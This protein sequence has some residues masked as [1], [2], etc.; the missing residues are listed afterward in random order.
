MVGTSRRLCISGIHPCVTTA[1]LKARFQ[2]FG[3]VI[4]GPDIIIRDRFD[5]AVIGSKNYAFAF[6]SMLLTDTQFLKFQTTFSNAKW[7]GMVLQIADASE[8]YTERLKREKMIYLERC[9]AVNAEHKLQNHGATQTLESLRRSNQQL[10]RCRISTISAEDKMVSKTC[11]SW[12]EG[13]GGLPLAVVRVRDP[14]THMVVKTQPVQ[15]LKRHIK[16]KSDCSNTKSDELT[17]SIQEMPY[18]GMIRYQTHQP[19]QDRLT[20]AIV[21]EPAVLSEAPEHDNSLF[22]ELKSNIKSNEEEIERVPDNLFESDDE[23]LIG[24]EHHSSSDIVGAGEYNCESTTDEQVLTVNAKAAAASLKREKLSQL[25]LLQSMGIK[26]EILS[27]S[28]TPH[29]SASLPILTSGCD[30][31]AKAECDEMLRSRC[32]VDNTSVKANMFSLGRNMLA[33]YSETSDEDDIA[34]E[35]RE[36]HNNQLKVFPVVTTSLNPADS[37]ERLSPQ[38]NQTENKSIYMGTLGCDR[39]SETSNESDAERSQHMGS[40]FDCDS[41]ETNEKPLSSSTISSYRKDSMLT[42]PKSINSGWQRKNRNKKNENEKPDSPTTMRSQAT[43]CFAPDTSQVIVRRE[44]RKQSNADVQDTSDPNLDLK[45]KKVVINS[46]FQSTIKHSHGTIPKIGTVTSFSFFGDDKCDS[47]APIS[48]EASGSTS[49]DT[50]AET[51]NTGFSFFG[52]A[53]LV[54]DVLDAPVISRKAHARPSI[55]TDTTKQ[56]ESKEAKLYSFFG[57]LSN[58]SNSNE[59]FMRDQNWNEKD[60]EKWIEMRGKLTED[61]KKRFKA[62]KRD[63]R[64]KRV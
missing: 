12:A 60:D 36:I 17:W 1:D 42:H 3:D 5:P 64:N 23:Q 21:G 48:L 63:C 31:I 41:E 58:S 39:Y 22:S 38:L 62:K 49:T 37:N 29:D 53:G 11:R 6:V 43:N 50:S 8:H 46:T 52:H 47:S 55:D 2:L 32:T 34:E 44:K 54:Q 33:E 7:R 19:L 25:S 59:N 13:P 4:A 14:K 18:C 56:A 16:M 10:N 30:M 61:F 9:R 57:K 40:S 45:K 15:V 20:T 35:A 28:V 51:N 26:A 24:L 27:P